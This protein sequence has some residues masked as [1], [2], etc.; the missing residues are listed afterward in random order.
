[1]VSGSVD[2]NIN[3][4]DDLNLG[5]GL[6]SETVLI[7]SADVVEI[8]DS[9]EVSVETHLAGYIVYVAFENIAA[10]GDAL[11]SDRLAI[12]LND[13]DWMVLQTDDG[14]ANDTGL[15]VVDADL[16]SGLPTSLDDALASATLPVCGNVVMTA[17]HRTARGTSLILGF[18]RDVAGPASVRCDWFAGLDGECDPELCSSVIGRLQWIGTCEEV[19]VWGPNTCKCV[20]TNGPMEVL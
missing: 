1:V 8:H 2:L 6:A 7:T 5:G 13:L 9:G 3:G 12:P 11:S 19:E 4:L 16:P 10:Y 14:A 15:A 17:G 18:A 20:F